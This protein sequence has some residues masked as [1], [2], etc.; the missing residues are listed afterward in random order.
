MAGRIQTLKD[1]LGHL[2]P[3]TVSRA[4]MM[5]DGTNLDYA[6]ENIPT[7]HIKLESDLLE[8]FNLPQGTTLHT[9]LMTY[10]QNA[11]NTVVTAEVVEQ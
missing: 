10:T 4:V 2:F 11:S 9:L 5:E 3:R 6:L 1:K 8:A 7:E